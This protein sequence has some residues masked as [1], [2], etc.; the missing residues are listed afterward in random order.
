MSIYNRYKARV[1]IFEEIILEPSII[2]PVS[3]VGEYSLFRV[4][5]PTV[6]VRVRVRVRLQLYQSLKMTMQCVWLEK[7]DCSCKKTFIGISSLK[8]KIC[9]I[10]YYL[11]RRIIYH[12]K[13]L[14]HFKTV[15]KQTFFPVNEA[16]CGRITKPDWE[17]T[18]SIGAV[19]AGIDKYFNAS[20]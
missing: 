14:L 18:R 1:L 5:V 15:S 10:F 6:R 8:K 11:V 4:R 13:T 16:W 7:Y 12:N 3:E 17:K 20:W 19:V 9:N 2:D